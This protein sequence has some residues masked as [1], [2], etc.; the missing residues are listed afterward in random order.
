MMQVS[1]DGGSITAV[2]DGCLAS[3]AEDT[4]L[5]RGRLEGISDIRLAPLCA[6]LD[7]RF[8]ELQQAFAHVRRL[9]E[10]RGEDGVDAMVIADLACQLEAQSSALRTAFERLEQWLRAG[11]PAS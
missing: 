11:F 5:L 6:E 1:E 2:L 7:S 3:I 10:S 9:A 4:A 8:A